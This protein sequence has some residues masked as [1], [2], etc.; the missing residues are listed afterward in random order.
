MAPF[1][2]LCVIL[3]EY[4]ACNT[5][6]VQLP[7][8]NTTAMAQWNFVWLCLLE[9]A[10]RSHGLSGKDT[11][12]KRV[13]SGSKGPSSF[14]GI[15]SKLGALVRGVLRIRVSYAVC[16]SLKEEDRP[17]GSRRKSFLRSKNGSPCRT[18]GGFLRPPPINGPRPVFDFK[19]ISTHLLRPCDKLLGSKHEAPNM[20][21][22][23]LPFF[24]VNPQLQEMRLI[25]D[26]ACVVFQTHVRCGAVCRSR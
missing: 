18:D 26:C 8:P 6:G 11:G 1:I 23:S 20:S 15:C 4:C 24:L 5:P 2:S 12:E 19:T 16:T 21:H 17:R 22:P 25:E 7:S 3:L 14:I 10:T 9:Q 13:H